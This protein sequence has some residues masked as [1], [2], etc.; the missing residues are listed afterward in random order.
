M[1]GADILQELL[2]GRLIVI[3]AVF[4]GLLLLVVVLATILRRPRR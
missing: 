1:D 3:G 4:L 2:F